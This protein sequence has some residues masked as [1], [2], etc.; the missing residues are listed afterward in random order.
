MLCG[1]SL[2]VGHNED[3]RVILPVL[4]FLG[5]AVGQVSNICGW[6]RMNGFQFAS[7]QGYLGEEVGQVPDILAGGRTF[8]LLGLEGGYQATALLRWGGGAGFVYLKC[9][10]YL[11]Y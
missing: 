6:E 3:W 8:H 11:F 1:S 4:E 7:H 10:N 2:T 5:E 9:G